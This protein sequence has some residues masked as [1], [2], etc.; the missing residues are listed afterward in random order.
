MNPER[1]T[2]L[3]D[4][5]EAEELGAF[6]VLDLLNVR[7]L[8]GF[9]G[10]SGACVVTPDEAV[11]FTDG[12]YRIQAA[13]ECPE[14][15]LRVSNEPLSVQVGAF[16]ACRGALRAGFEA[17]VM[18]CEQFDQVTAAAPE[19]LLVGRKEMVSSMRA[20]K[21][22]WEIALLRKAAA[23]TDEAFRE[24]LP[25]IRPGVSERKL[26]L[27]LAYALGRCGAE[28]ESFP[29]IVASGE[30]S[31]L[32]HARPTERILKEGE[33]VL[34][35]FGGAVGGYAADITRTVFIGTPPARLAEVYEVVLQAQEEALEAIRPGVPGRDVDSVARQVITAAGYG[36][37]FGHGLGHMLGLDVHDGPALSPRSTVTLQEG[38]VL[39]VEP[40]V[41][42][43]GV[44][45]IRIEDDVVVTADGCD[46]LT[47]SPKDLHIIEV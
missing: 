11:L 20:V 17:D 39:T 44:G 19:A 3:R 28:R 21:D 36:D 41:Y 30:R 43:E 12:R 6:I 46:I 13:E 40:G 24:I 38:M 32:P 5:M 10:S 1:L 31:A 45:G 35:D 14:W 42:L 9:T 7:W 47:R 27:E 26:A 16:L 33:P 37:C 4:R 23:V 34:L 2:R 15:E 25:H 18:T 22:P 8:S 29:G